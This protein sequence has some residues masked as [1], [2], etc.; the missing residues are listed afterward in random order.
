M[1]QMPITSESSFFSAVFILQ[2]SLHFQDCA[3]AFSSGRAKVT[4]ALSFLTGPALG[5]FEP[6]LFGPALPAWAGDWD[7]FHMELEANFGPFDPVGE[8]KAEIEMLVMT[9]GSHSMNYFVEFN[10]LASRIQ[11]DD[12]TLFRQAYKGLARRIKNEMVH[13]DRPVMLLD[14]HKLVQAIDYCYWE[15]KAEITREAN[16]TSK[17]DPKIARNPKA[18]P[19]GKAPENPKSGLDLTGKLGKDGK[20]TPQERQRRM[21]NSL[22]LFCGKTGH[23]AKECP[24][25]TAIAAQARATVMELQESFVEEA[26]KD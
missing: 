11:W 7:L 12:H 8:A 4:Y 24:K 22:C 1:A 6:A 18:A 5:W 9:E 17:G 3:N 13:Y 16:P 14:L 20:L 23:I 2:C 25:S 15:W 19:K 10:R 21:D 26:K